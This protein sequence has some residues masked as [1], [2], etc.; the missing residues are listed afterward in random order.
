MCQSLCSLTFV[1][2]QKPRVLSQ[3][4]VAVIHLS[5]EFGLKTKIL[6]KPSFKLQ[7]PV[8][9]LL[10]RE[11]GCSALPTKTLRVHGQAQA[12]LPGSTC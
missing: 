1:F 3:T 4:S 6:T 10:Q 8:N 2:Q 5:Q 11:K 7:V 9:G 12:L